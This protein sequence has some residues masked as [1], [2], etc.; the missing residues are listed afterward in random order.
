MDALR[1]VEARPPELS[2]Q[3][4]ERTKRRFGEIR[5]SLAGIK[6]PN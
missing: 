2:D 6:N 4:I 3:D 1:H 5:D